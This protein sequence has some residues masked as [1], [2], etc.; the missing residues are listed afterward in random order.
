MDVFR[1]PDG[2]GSSATDSDRPHSNDQLDLN[3]WS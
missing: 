2:N 3:P 1:S